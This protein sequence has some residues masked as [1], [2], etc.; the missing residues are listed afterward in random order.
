[1]KRYNTARRRFNGGGETIRTFRKE[2]SRGRGNKRSGSCARIKEKTGEREREY[3]VY[4]NSEGK[5]SSARSVRNNAEMKRREY[6][7]YREKERTTEREEKNERG[8]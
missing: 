8:G 1:M 6:S 7:M 3:K 5:K 2:K 4:G